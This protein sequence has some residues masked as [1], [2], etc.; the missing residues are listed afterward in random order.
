[1]NE[2]IINKI[3]EIEKTVQKIK[4]KGETLCNNIRNMTPEE[5][6]ERICNERNIYTRT[7]ESIREQKEA[8]N[9]AREQINEVKERVKAG[10]IDKEDIVEALAK[11]RDEFVEKSTRAKNGFQR[12][13][14][15]IDDADIAEK[16]NS[17]FEAQQMRADS[18]KL[19]LSKLKYKIQNM[20]RD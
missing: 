13:C 6:K 15:K 3:E 7:Q 20:R 4:A 1:M 9:K 16:I 17:E 5:A 8:A 11:I 2:N 19:E 12:A 18:V 10:D 14:K